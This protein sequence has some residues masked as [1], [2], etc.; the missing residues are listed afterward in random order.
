MVKGGGGEVP[1]S[2]IDCA[3]LLIAPGLIDIQVSAIFHPAHVK[4][5]TKR[6]AVLFTVC[7]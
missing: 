7:L 4:S 3:G 2:K 1:K 5:S 6:T